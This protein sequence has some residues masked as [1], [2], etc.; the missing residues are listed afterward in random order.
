MRKAQARSAVRRYVLATAALF[1][2]AV[3]Y[4]RFRVTGLSASLASSAS[5][6]VVSL[7]PPDAD[8]ALPEGPEPFVNHLLARRVLLYKRD[9]SG[10]LLQHPMDGRY[11][12]E[13]TKKFPESAT[14]WRSEADVSLGSRLRST[15]RDVGVPHRKTAELRVDATPV[16]PAAGSAVAGASEWVDVGTAVRAGGGRKQRHN[17]VC[18]RQT[19]C[20]HEVP[21]RAKN[22]LRTLH[23]LNGGAMQ[24]TADGQAWVES[25]ADGGPWLF[26]FGTVLATKDFVLLLDASRDMWLKIKPAPAAPGEPWTASRVFMGQTKDNESDEDD[27][28]ERSLEQKLRERD[29]S[30]SPWSLLFESC[31]PRRT[32]RNVSKRIDD[33]RKRAG[34]G[35]PIHMVFSVDSGK[36]YEWLALAFQF[37]WKR[38]QNQA[39]GSRFTRLLSTP[40]ARPDHLMDK[41]PTFVAPLPEEFEQG[42]HYLPYNKIVSVLRWIQAEH[43]NLPADQIIAIMDVDI[44]LLEDLSYLAVDVRKGHPMGAKGFMSFTGEGSMYDKVVERYCPT[45]KGGADPLAVPYFIHKDDLLALAPRWYDMCRKIRK[46]TQPW[47]KVTDWRRKSPLQ[48]SWT[49]EQWA[50]LLTAAEMGLRHRVREDMSAFTSDS[51]QSLDEPMI[52]FSDWTVGRGANGEKLRWSKGEDALRVIPNVDPARGAVNKAMIEA[53]QDFRAAHYPHLKPAWAEK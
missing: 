21:R 42:D 43:A 50:Y 40:H 12:L 5:R 47:E 18:Y 30:F 31:D 16:G 53:L 14:A 13:F 32:C 9:G 7:L 20:V 11:W 3:L 33:A 8:P 15:L 19:G 44:V 10:Y 27:D 23:K 45:C 49:A 52:H 51:T 25:N 26:F 48:L 38:T 2:F 34:A 28:E 36:R 17:L 46:D 35:P 29:D 1:V 6:G 41:I 24:E 22:E 4:Y 39:K 37:W